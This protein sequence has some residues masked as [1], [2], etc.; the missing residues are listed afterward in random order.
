[1]LFYPLTLKRKQKTKAATLKPKMVSTT[2][3]AAAGLN[4]TT[5]ILSTT[6][7]PLQSR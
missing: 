6:A 3:L 1:M 2:S 7:S 4:L 5:L